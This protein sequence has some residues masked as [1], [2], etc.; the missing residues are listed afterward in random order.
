M[1]IFSKPF[2]RAFIGSNSYIMEQK[3]ITR[4]LNLY[5]LML[6]ATVQFYS[7]KK[8]VAY[9][10]N[11]YLQ[12]KLKLSN[13]TIKMSLHY[14]KDFRL[15]EVSYFKKKGGSS[16]ERRIKLTSFAR[17]MLG[18]CNSEEMKE[19]RNFL[20]ISDV[21]MDTF[22]SNESK[23]LEDGVID[24]KLSNSEFLFLSLIIN[25]STEESGVK[26]KNKTLAIGLGENENALKKTIRL[27]R[28]RKLISVI[29]VNGEG[30]E[31]R[32]IRIAQDVFDKYL[33]S[34]IFA[35]KENPT[36]TTDKPITS[37]PRFEEL[38]KRYPNKTDIDKAYTLFDTLPNLEADKVINSLDAFILFANKQIEKNTKNK[39]GKFAYISKLSNYISSKK[40]LEYI[41]EF[42]LND[43]DKYTAF[44]YRIIGYFKD[45]KK[46]KS[47][48]VLYAGDES[49]KQW[50]LDYFAYIIQNGQNAYMSDSVQST[51]ANFINIEYRD[52][53]RSNLILEVEEIE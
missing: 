45:F 26:L 6:L 36:P 52:E 12:K 8:G 18:V 3:H 28:I 17:E 11:K 40:Y 5:E 51:L 14:L 43:I 41:H 49:A 46:L 47:F 13:N 7:E 33:R 9:M 35:R 1:I 25:L 39:D 31:G 30:R 20:N 21:A 22:F 10:D 44:C 16:E 32:E 38:K 34:E 2:S 24:K 27:L 53:L 48:D 29:K 37:S 50:L 4:K 19:S 15:I 23:I 42:E